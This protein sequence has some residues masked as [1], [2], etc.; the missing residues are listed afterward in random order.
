MKM[1]GASCLLQPWAGLRGWAQPSKGGR[2]GDRVSQGALICP[3]PAS[4]GIDLGLPDPVWSE[5]R[6]FPFRRLLV[7]WGAESAAPDSRPGPEQA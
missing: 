1:G 3:S 2:S 5:K 6:G 7:L 4:P